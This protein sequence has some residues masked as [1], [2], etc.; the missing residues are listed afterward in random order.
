MSKPKT[1]IYEIVALIRE[2]GPVSPNRLTELTGD[3]RQSV[4]KYIRQAHDMGL[5]HI[6]DF[7]PSP[8]GGNRTVKLYAYGKGIDAKRVYAID[9]AR[10]KTIEKIRAKRTAL[11]RP[12][13][14]T[15]V[16]ALFG[17]VA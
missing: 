1:K 15:Y 8:L 3:F 9:R 10:Q 16:E 17:A 5:I 4:D 11:N 14:D 6:A 13:R 12:H 2:H 7:G